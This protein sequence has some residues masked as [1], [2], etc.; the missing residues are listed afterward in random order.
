MEVST[1]T[2]FFARAT[3]QRGVSVVVRAGE[4]VGFSEAD[5]GKGD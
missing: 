2:P 4:L 5:G 3:P 1:A